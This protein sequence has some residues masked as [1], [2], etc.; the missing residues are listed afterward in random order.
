MNRFLRKT[1]LAALTALSA[2]AIAGTLATNV[3]VQQHS[4]WCWAANSVSVLNWYGRYPSQCGVV[5]WAFGSTT[6]CGNTTY[7]WNSPNN[8]TNAIYGASG[9]I[10]DILSHWG[11]TS[12]GVPYFMTWADVVTS[13]DHRAPFIIARQWNTGG[14]H[15]MVGNGYWPDTTGMGYNWVSY[16][17]PAPGEGNKWELY[18]SVVTNDTSTWKQTLKLWW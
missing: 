17:D 10:Q 9:S 7:Y 2:P 11:V 8:R 5:N 16:M 13:I 1:L 3:V 14:G 15:V 12:R 6:A 18:W 4:N